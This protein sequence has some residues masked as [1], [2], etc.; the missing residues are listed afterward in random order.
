[1]KHHMRELTSKSVFHYCHNRLAADLHQSLGLDKAQIIIRQQT[2]ISISSSQSDL[3]HLV[4]RPFHL[5]ITQPRLFA[6]GTCHPIPSCSLPIARTPAVLTL[7]LLVLAI[8]LLPAIFVV[9]IILI[10]AIV[11]SFSITLLVTRHRL[12]SAISVP[13]GQVSLDIP[14]LILA[15]LWL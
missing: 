13:I 8:V 7:T 6:F 2:E 12:C 5:L 11:G 1:M 9:I 10:L 3:F 15:L 14:I 4:H